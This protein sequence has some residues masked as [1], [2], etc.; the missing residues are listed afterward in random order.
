MKNIGGIVKTVFFLIVI[1]VLAVVL[2]SIY[3]NENN[4]R[5]ASIGLG[6]TRLLIILAVLAA[7]ASSVYALM[8]SEGSLKKSLMRIGVLLVIFVIG[9]AMAGNE[10]LPTYEKMNIT[11]ASS[12]RIGGLLNGMFLTAGITV[13]AA[14]VTS[15]LN[16]FKK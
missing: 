4:D 3:V 16:T 7:L 10:V 14:V 1:I 9:Y 15:I 11:P 8:V 12:K 6:F 2:L 5:G 13:V